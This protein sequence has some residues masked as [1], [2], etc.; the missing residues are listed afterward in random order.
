LT[1]TK[2]VGPSGVGKTQFCHQLVVISLLKSLNSKSPP[3]LNE[4]TENNTNSESKNNSN[5][6]KLF[7][8]KSHVI[9]FDTENTFSPQR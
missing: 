1:S 6:E 3:R 4:N 8:S 5:D 9:Y 2:I 7:D